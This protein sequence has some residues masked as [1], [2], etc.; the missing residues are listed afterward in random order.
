MIKKI[1]LLTFCIL[2]TGLIPASRAEEQTDN[3]LILLRNGQSLEGKISRIDDIY[4]VQFSDGEIRVKASD[5][6]LVCKDLD[7]AYQRK[8]QAISTDSLREHLE[9]AQWCQ[10]HKLYDQA[11][12]ELADAAILAPGNPMVGYLQRRLKAA[13]EPLPDMPK[14]TGAQDQSIAN[15]E[16]DRVVRGLPPKAMEN[17]TRTVQPLLINNCSASGCHGPQSKNGFC[18]QRIPMDSPA[19]RRLTQRNIVAV[20]QY[21]DR[22]NPMESRLLT[23]PANPHGNSKTP[24]FSEHQT[25]QYKHLFDWVMQLGPKVEPEVPST[26][27]DLGTIKSESF[28]ELEAAKAAPQ[29]LSSEAQ[30]AR[31]LQSTATSSDNQPMINSANNAQIK[32]GKGQSSNAATQAAFQTPITEPSKTLKHAGTDLQSQKKKKLALPNDY[33]PKDAFDAEIFNRQFRKLSQPPDESSKHL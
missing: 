9:L 5:V 1:A 25:A 11:K 31:P 30:N 17:F 10:R 23:M 12:A 27:P 18:L 2:I 26:M 19:G 6:E 24:V 13:I 15:Q 22:N 16:L 33:K 7:E 32:N 28:A 8:R 14:T 3:R 21:V 20:L 29:M 4:H